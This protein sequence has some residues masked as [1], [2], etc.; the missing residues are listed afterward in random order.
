MYLLVIPYKYYNEK[1]NVYNI[2]FFLSTLKTQTDCFCFSMSLL[3]VLCRLL[4]TV[5]CR[6]MIGYPVFQISI[7]FEY[8]WFIVETGTPI[9]KDT[10][11]HL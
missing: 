10:K 7:C 5:S 11:C 4:V 3:S 6:S 1:Y 8:R 2:A 9:H